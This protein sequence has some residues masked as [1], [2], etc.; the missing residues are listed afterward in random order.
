MV[1]KGTESSI[2][3]MF[4]I[5]TGKIHEVDFSLS[6]SRHPFSICILDIDWIP[7]KFILQLVKPHYN[8][9]NTLLITMMVIIIT[10][11]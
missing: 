5:Q 3:L 1:N 6:V 9:A 8:D 10:T 4:P 7:W 11:I 2:H